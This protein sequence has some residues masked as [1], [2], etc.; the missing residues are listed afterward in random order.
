MNELIIYSILLLM[1]LTH[2]ILASLLYRKINR[3]KQLSFHEKNDWR[4]RAL[5]FPAYYWFAYKKHKARQK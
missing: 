5:V 1:V 4:L 2:L 3:D